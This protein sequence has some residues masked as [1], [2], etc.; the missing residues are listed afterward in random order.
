[1]ALLLVT[2]PFYWGT[3]ADTPMK[4]MFVGLPAPDASE[5]S[6]R[7]LFFAYGTMRLSVWCP[8]SSPVDAKALAASKRKMKGTCGAQLGCNQGWVMYKK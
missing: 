3:A 8:I 1:M 7:E 6:V 2:I 4:M 5:E